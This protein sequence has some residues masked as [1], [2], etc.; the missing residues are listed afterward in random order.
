L[1]LPSGTL[2]DVVVTVNGAMALS[3][4][5]SGNKQLWTIGKSDTSYNDFGVSITI[6]ASSWTQFQNFTTI[7]T[8]QLLS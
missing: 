3:I 1:N 5:G 6:R 7:F 8:L 2:I 4:D